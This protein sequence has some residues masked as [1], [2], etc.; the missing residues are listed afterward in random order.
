MIMIP[1]TLFGDLVF[2]TT[3]FNFILGRIPLFGKSCKPGKR[4][5]G[6]QDP[7]RPSDTLS[8]A[9]LRTPKSDE[10]NLGCD[11]KIKSSYLGEEL[12]RSLDRK[13]SGAMSDCVGG[14]E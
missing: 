9:I 5:L 11:T 4:E 10:K 1:F 3:V 6:G 7:L 13:S 14:S 8:E 12:A 2:I